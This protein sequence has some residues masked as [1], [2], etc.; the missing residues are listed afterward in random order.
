MFQFGPEFLKFVFEGEFEVFFSERAFIEVGLSFGEDF[1]LILG[2]A[3]AGQ[4]FDEGVGVEGGLRL[5]EGHN[6]GW[7][8]SL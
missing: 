6:S 8:R 5:H 1:G 7:G 2:H 3:G 4:A